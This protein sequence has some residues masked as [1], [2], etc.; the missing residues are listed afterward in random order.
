MSRKERSRLEVLSRVRDGQLSLAEAAPLMGVCYRQVRRIYAA[1][2]RD[3]DAGLVHKLRGRA[4]NRRTDPAV[5]ESVLRA[6]R[7]K[8]AGFGPT[9]ACEH[10]AKASSASVSH[11]TLWR[12]LGAEGLLERRRRRAKHRSRRAR[13]RCLGEMVQMDGSWHDWFEGRSDGGA[14]CCLMV[15]VDDATGRVSCRFYDRETLWAAFD[16]F[17]RY[18]KAHGLPRAVYVDRAAMYVPAEDGAPTQFG[19]AMDDLGVELILANSPQAKGRVERMNATLQDRLAKALRLAGVATVD[20]ANRFLEETPFLVELNERFGVEPAGKADLHRRVDASP[21]SRRLTAANVEEAL[22]VH[23]ERAVGRDWC[24]QWRGRVL[25]VDAS[26]AA[27]DLPRPGRRVTV[28][29]RLD[30]ALHV[31]HEGRDLLWRELGVRPTAPKR[32]RAK[33]PVKNNR[34]YVPSPAHPWNAPGPGVLSRRKGLVGC[35]SS[36]LAAGRSEGDSSTAMKPGT[37]LLR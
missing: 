29:E 32:Q 6:Y 33:G 22:C 31:R 10:L 5:R 2:V 8:Y 4:S 16:V 13:R 18:A 17:A 37:V 1:Y 20:A 19:R 21:S 14:W 9:L 3:G 36:P 24:V 35:A 26:H 34:R 25:Q 11:D 23:E 15:L 27:L 12:W 28:V 30:G 7:E